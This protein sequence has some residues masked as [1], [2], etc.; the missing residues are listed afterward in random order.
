MVNGL[1]TARLGLLAIDLIRPLPF[2]DLPRPALN[3]LAGKPAARVRASAERRKRPSAAPK[4][5]TAEIR[6][7]LAL[8]GRLPL[9]AAPS[10]TRTLALTAVR[11]LRTARS[12]AHRSAAEQ[13]EKTMAL[14]DYT[15][16]QLLEA[17]V[18]F[19]HQAHRWNPKMGELHL[20]HPQQ[21][22]HHRPRPERADAAPGAAGRERHRRQGRPHPVRRHQAAGA[23]RRSPRP[24]SAARSTTST[25]AGS[26]AR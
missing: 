25:R 9:Y 2:H 23:G 5:V 18:H 24:P 12:G 14:P 20:R 11:W 6:L 19:G 1:L 26:A 17:G 21:H 13:P 22:P 3:D 7:F 10:H 15:M 16:R 4:A 8:P